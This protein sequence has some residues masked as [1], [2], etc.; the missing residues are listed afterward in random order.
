[1]TADRGLISLSIFSH[2]CN[3]GLVAAH[4][5]GWSHLLEV[6]L[7]RLAIMYD[8]SS[9]RG[10]RSLPTLFLIVVILINYLTHWLLTFPTAMRS[11]KCFIE[12][13]FSGC[14]STIMVCHRVVFGTPNFSIISEKLDLTIILL[15]QVAQIPHSVYNWCWSVGI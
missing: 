14:K 13:H 12:V 8:S 1:M 5:Q 2:P 4:L 7:H 9:L 6:H 15:S 3:G 10:K 11:H